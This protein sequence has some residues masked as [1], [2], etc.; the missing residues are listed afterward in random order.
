LRAV[1]DLG[2]NLERE[3][4]LAVALEKLGEHFTLLRSSSVYRT[5]PVGMADQPDFFNL[6][7]EVDTD[8]D[9]DEIRTILR[10]IED[11]MGRDRKAPKFGPRIIDI[12]LLLHGQTVDPGRNVPHPQTETQ[13]F[14]VLPLA[15]LYPD[16][17]HPVSGRL[18]SDTCRELLGG[19][20]LGDAGILGR[21]AL[22]SLPL[23]PRAR[24][25]LLR[26]V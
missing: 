16:G 25:A 21:V 17:R 2:T 1:F 13:V 15:E 3:V 7:L 20:A 4:S 23:G 6:S 26:P 12:D 9:V 5:E 24:E 8:R 22:D 11:A 19:R 14:V 18:W 10:G